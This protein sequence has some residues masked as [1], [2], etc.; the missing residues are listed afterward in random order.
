MEFDAEDVFSV[1]A[2]EEH[3]L[4]VL[5]S[6][7]AQ[8][9]SEEITADDESI[10]MFIEE[11]SNSRTTTLPSQPFVVGSSLSISSCDTGVVGVTVGT[12]KRHKSASVLWK[13]FSDSEDGM[14]RY[15]SLCRARYS[16]NT[17]ISTIKGHFEIHHKE[18]LDAITDQAGHATE[19]YGSNDK[20]KV[21][22]LSKLLIEWI[23]SDQ[24]PFCIVDNKR[25]CAL[26]TAFDGRYQMPTRQTIAKK[27][28]QL[29]EIEKV[30]IKGILSALNSKMAITTDLWTACT[31]QSY[32]S[33]TLH[34]IENDWQLRRILLD[35]VPMHERHTGINLKETLMESIRFFDIGKNILSVTTDNA[36][37]MDTFA[38]ALRVALQDEFGNKEFARVRCAAHILNLMVNQG[39]S[40]ASMSITKARR[41]ASH[42]KNSQRQFEELKKIFKMK[43]KPFL[44]PQ[45]DVPTRWNSTYLM[46]VRLQEIREMMDI[47]VASN[48]SLKTM[49]LEE[50]D[51]KQLGVS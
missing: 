33:V 5:A 45:S 15:C 19:P 50:D 39:L 23:I 24:Q 36:G 17:G 29:Y 18:H 2:S 12:K 38:R 37:N 9:E 40:K 16:K 11:Q 26:V 41:F 3:D 25:F 4:A 27:V 31:N 21:E 51:W 47:L 6:K 30:N 14:H 34:W 42:I 49:Y 7:F 8:H 44:V 46:I 48:P 28:T 20:Q 1:H 35:L 32:M 43:E 13:Y 22:N 10:E